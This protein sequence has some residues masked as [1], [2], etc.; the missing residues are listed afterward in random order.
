MASYHKISNGK[1]DI[2]LNNDYFRTI[3]SDYRL[4]RVT[5]HVTKRCVIPFSEIF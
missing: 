4:T 3:L 1:I 2:W 5:A